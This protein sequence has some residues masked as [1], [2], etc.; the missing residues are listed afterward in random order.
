MLQPRAGRLAQAA[1]SAA[2]LILSGKGVQRRELRRRTRCG[3]PEAMSAQQPESMTLTMVDS[4][5]VKLPDG[6]SCHRHVLLNQQVGFAGFAMRVALLQCNAG[7]FVFVASIT[8]A[9]RWIADPSQDGQHFLRM[10][11]IRRALLGAVGGTDVFLDRQQA[12][13]LHMW[14]RGLLLLCTYEQH[15]DVEELLPRCCRCAP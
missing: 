5:D 8:H 1:V 12:S 13:A 7:A 14:T 11:D 15:L 6:S 4:R 9:T 3:L 10:P 2:Q